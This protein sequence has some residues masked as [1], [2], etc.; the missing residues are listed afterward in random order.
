MAGWSMDVIELCKKY[1][2]DGVVGID[3]AGDESLNCESNPGHKKAFEVKV[4]IFK[5]QIAS[6]EKI[7]GQFQRCG[8]FQSKLEI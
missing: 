7:F 8:L 6:C 4:N 2:N 3:L 1:R 5:L